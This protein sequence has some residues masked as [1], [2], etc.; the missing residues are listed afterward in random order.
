MAC[1]EAYPVLLDFHTAPIGG[2]FIATDLA[3]S[4]PRTWQILGKTE[5]AP[6]GGPFI[7]TDLARSMPTYMADT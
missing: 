7:A 3:R 5:S 4:M 2:P 1:T 6:I